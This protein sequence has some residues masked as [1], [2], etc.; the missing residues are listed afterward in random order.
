LEWRDLK[1]LKAASQFSMDDVLRR[2]KRKPPDPERYQLKQPF[3][4][5]HPISIDSPNQ[6]H[7]EPSEMPDELSLK[8]SFKG[9]FRNS[10][11]ESANHGH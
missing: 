1:S 8:P 11:N 4:L 10:Q 9:V 3:R 6:Y 5:I 7:R 2:I